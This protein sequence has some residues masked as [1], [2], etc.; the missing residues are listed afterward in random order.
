MRHSLLASVLS[1]QGESGIVMIEI[2]RLPVLKTMAV[3]AVLRGGAP[4]MPEAA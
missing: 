1:L 4:A 2:A 3:Q